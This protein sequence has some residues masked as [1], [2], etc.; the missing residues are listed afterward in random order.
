MARAV[1]R[2]EP[3]SADEID[4]IVA[5]YFAMLADE[6]RGAPYNKAA[7]NRALVERTGR[8]RPSIEFKHRNISAVLAS[9]GHAW[10]DGYKPLFHYQEALGAALLRRFAGEAATEAS[11]SGFSETPAPF[12]DPPVWRNESRSDALARL[13]QGFDYRIAPRP[14]PDPPK[15]EA[16]E[17]LVRKIDPA[18]RDARN[19]ALGRD[20]EAFVLELE[21]RRLVE[22]DR[23]DLARKVRWVSEEDGDGAGYDIRSFDPRGSERLIEVK[24][25]RGGERT[26]FF[27]TRNEHALSTERPDAFRLYRLARFENRPSLIGVP[28]PLAER[29]DLEAAVYQGRLR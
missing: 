2:T 17:R 7:H 21:R 8:S 20:G 22:R 19:R 27:L 28:P 5:D 4:F 11:A 13:A 1:A 23:P 25:T 12:V 14:T 9:S 3:W 26:P 18:A 29:I 24:T 15:S 16:F 10:I 6:L